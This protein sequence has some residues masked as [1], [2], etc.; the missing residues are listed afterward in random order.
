MEGSG[1]DAVSMDELIQAGSSRSGSEWEQRW[2]SVT[3][4]DICTFIY[5]SGTTGP[6]KGCVISHGNY[7][8]MVTMALD[9]SVLDSDTTTYLFL[10]LAH[11]FAL[12]IQ[13]LSFDL[14]GNIAYWERDPLKI[15]PNLAEVKPD[16]FPSVPR[17]FEKIYTAATGEVEKSGGIKKLVF[18]W[19]IGVGRK[20]RESERAGKPSAGCCASSTGSP[21]SRSS[22]RSAPCSAA[23]SGTASP[24][25]PRSTPRSCASSTPRECSSSR[26][27]A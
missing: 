9:E 4:D 7:R 27:G 10:P 12:L 19:A 2:R 23:G 8:S 11:S 24:A 22:P 14:G 18:N 25:P 1:G 20:V 16:Y 21:T 26:A 3:P 17:I 5:T 15:I 6:P 13:F